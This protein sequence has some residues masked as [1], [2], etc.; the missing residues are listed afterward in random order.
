PADE[1]PHG[2]VGRPPGWSRRLLPAALQHAGGREAFPHPREDRPMGL[3]GDQPPRPRHR[4]V[5]RGRHGEAEPDELAQ[6]RRVRGAP[7]EPA[8]GV[9]PFEV[10]DPQQPEVPARWQTPPPHHRRVELLTLRLRE[11]VNTLRVEDRVQPGVERMARRHRQL[12]GHD[13]HRRLLALPRAHS[14]DRSLCGHPLWVSWFSV[15]MTAEGFTTEASGL[16]V[17]ALLAMR[18]R[19]GWPPTGGM[20][21][22]LVPPAG[23]AAGARGPRLACGPA[24]RRS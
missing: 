22:P 11:P 10:P 7:P 2:S 16:P 15:K 13:P 24:P 14:H 21:M 1:T 17:R 5:I 3:Q 9:E 8:L 12:A 18:E 4:R 23:I 19:S 20:F 6:A